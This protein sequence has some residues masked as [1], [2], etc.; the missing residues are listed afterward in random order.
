MVAFLLLFW[1]VYG[2]MH[3]YLYSK[4]RQ[5]NLL[6]GG[7]SIA[8]VC[9]LTFMVL[10]PLLAV[11][12][13]RAG[14]FWAAWSVSIVGHSWMAIIWWFCVLALLG[15]LWNLALRGLSL[16]TPAAKSLVLPPGPALAAIGVLVVMAAAWGVYEAS[17]IRL[18]RLDVASTR[19]PQGSAPLR[20]VQI[21]D[22]H[23]GLIV[24][25]GRL[26]KVLKLVEEAQPDLLVSTGD[27]V[28]ASFSHLEKEAGML[29]QLRPPLGKFAVLGNHEFYAGLDNA[30]KMHDAA[31]FR[32]LRGECVT[33]AYG[34]RLAGVDDPAGRV[35]GRE[36]FL[37]EGGAL[38]GSEHTKLT[39][40][41][42]HRPD[43]SEASVGLFDLQLSGHTHGGQI[44]PFGLLSALGNQYLK[45]FHRLGGGSA[46]YVTLGAGTW[47]PPMRLL[48]P[49]EVTLIII[50]PAK[51]H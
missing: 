39:I 30:L 27:L 50:R 20:V 37:E 1:A 36:L 9:F 32:L 40:F 23:L 7:L 16:L 33:L 51:G 8:A 6:H 19:I 21:S 49:P 4:L 18:K 13:D 2:G 31:G 11:L 41:L 34:V 28:D 43:V 26:R 5:S 29:A 22:I 38:F 3:F 10:A 17:A 12:L 14:A 45:G 48:A 47:G 42:K 24:R 25:G 46:I 15:D 35:V 44:F